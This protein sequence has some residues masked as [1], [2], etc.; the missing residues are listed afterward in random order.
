MIRFV[1][2][3]IKFVFAKVIYPFSMIA[4]FFLYSLYFFKHNYMPLFGLLFFVNFIIENALIQRSELQV[5][6]FVLWILCYHFLV[7]Q[8][9]YLF[10]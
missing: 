7:H 8:F 5:I 3:N 2:G 6:L 4:L 9:G 1:V 10:Y